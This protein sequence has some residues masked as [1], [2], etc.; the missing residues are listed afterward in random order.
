MDLPILEIYTDGMNRK[1]EKTEKKA[2][3]P[4]GFLFLESGNIGLLTRM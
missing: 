3:H 4:I 1:E 2:Y